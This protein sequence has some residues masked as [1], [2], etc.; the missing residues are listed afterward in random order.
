MMI[1]LIRPAAKRFAGPLSTWTIGANMTHL[2][3]SSGEAESKPNITIRTIDDNLDWFVIVRR[4]HE[5]KR[6]YK[7]YKSPYG[8]SC[9]Q[10][11]TSERLSPEADVEGQAWEMKNIAHAIRKK[12]TFESKRCAVCYHKITGT[13]LLWSPK[14][15]ATPTALTKEEAEHLVNEILEKVK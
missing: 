13:F 3:R 10:A 6:W 4:E 9:D 12:R 7:K 2:D 1:T 11:M 14:N 15:S 5:N 8:I